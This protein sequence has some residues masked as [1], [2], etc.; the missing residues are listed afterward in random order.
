M[1]LAVGSKLGPNGILSLIGAG[2][3]GD[4]WMRGTHAWAASW[5]SSSEELEQ[6]GT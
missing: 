2:E 4:V 6:R 5:P 1:T 3:I